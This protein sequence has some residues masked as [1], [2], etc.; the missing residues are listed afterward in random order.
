[1][2]LIE[3]TNSG[4]LYDS[5]AMLLTQAAG[6]GLRERGRAVLALAGG[7]TPMPIYRHLAVSGL[8]WPRI[9]LLPTDERWVAPDHP[10]S[11]LRAIGAAI[12]AAGANHRSLAPPEPGPEPDT[13]IARRSLADLA[14]PFDAVLLGMGADGHF[15]SLFPGAPELARGLDPETTAGALVTVPDPLPPAAPFP[16]VTLTLARLLDTRR[17]ILVI[18]GQGKLAVLRAAARP[19]A[20]PRRLP[21]AALAQHAGNALEVHWSP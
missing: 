3:H 5:V 9:T 18:R 1:M 14:E 19:D 15:A 17:V 12:G 2:K 4:E 21:V 11:N 8:D 20:D 6:D 13:E 10:A 16:R 7:N